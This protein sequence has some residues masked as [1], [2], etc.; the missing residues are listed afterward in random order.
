MAYTCID[1][2]TARY[3]CRACRHVYDVG[4]TT[5]LGHTEPD[6]ERDLKACPACDSP[7]VVDVDDPLAHVAVDPA[8]NEPL[9]ADEP[10]S[11]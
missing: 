2:T 1:R 7:H 6:R 10:T 11:S 3:R 8:E 5:E 4:F 9:E